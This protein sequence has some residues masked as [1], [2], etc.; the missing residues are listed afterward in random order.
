MLFY[1]LKMSERS[2]KIDYISPKSTE[3][4]K[5]NRNRNCTCVGRE[6]RRFG[7]NT[8]EKI[9]M[10][11]EGNLAYIPLRDEIVMT[12]YRYLRKSRYCFKED[13]IGD[14]L[15]TLMENLPA[16]LARYTVTKAP[17]EAYLFKTCKLSILDA[18]RTRR[19]A[20]AK[21]VLGE[22]FSNESRFFT[23]EEPFRGFEEA[24][25][26]FVRLLRGTMSRILKKYRPSDY[27]YR[28]S[29]LIILL[30]S[31]YYLT[32]GEKEKICSWGEFDRETVDQWLT[33]LYLSTEQARKTIR[34]CEMRRNRYA[35]F[36]YEPHL[37]EASR[38][39]N[40]NIICERLERWNRKLNTVKK[41][42]RN[43]RIADLLHIDCSFIDRLLQKVK[44]DQKRIDTAD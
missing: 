18:R 34:L 26:D 13:E 30:K 36:V 39:M 15:C 20:E 22:Y 1:S 10:Y 12:A 19:T 38:R 2:F 7:M 42:P 35:S 5:K 43:S 29:L 17:F 41:A 8:N 4:G 9:L 31:G 33:E 44:R 37:T 16:L 23:V 32:E 3:S 28:L 24:E 11:K 27:I 14:C 40:Y 6:G 25:K 21:A